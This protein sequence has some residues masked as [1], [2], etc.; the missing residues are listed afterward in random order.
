MT[1]MLISILHILA[2]VHPASASSSASI[3]ASQTQAFL[4]KT[5][6][7]QQQ[8]QQQQQRPI[9]YIHRDGITSPKDASSA[10][11]HES[12]TKIALV[13]LSEEGLMPSLNEYR[14]QALHQNENPVAPFILEKWIKPQIIDLDKHKA[15]HQGKKTSDEAASILIG[16]IIAIPANANI[17]NMDFLEGSFYSPLLTPSSVAS[18][19][20]SSSLSSSSTSSHNQQDALLGDM[21]ETIGCLVDCIILFYDTTCSHRQTAIVRLVKG[22]ER[23]KA[24]NESSARKDKDIHILILAKDDEAMEELY[25]IR[26][27]LTEGDEK[28]GEMIQIVPIKL[29]FSS[30][31]SNA[32]LGVLKIV[33][34]LLANVVD[35][36]VHHKEFVPMDEFPQFAK[37]VYSKLGGKVDEQSRDFVMQTRRVGTSAHVHASELLQAVVERK[38]EE[39]AIVIHDKVA[40]LEEKQDDVLMDDQKMPILE[41]GRDSTDILTLAS[42]VLNTNEVRSRIVGPFDGD[43]VGE[44]RGKFILKGNDHVRRLFENQLQSL[45]EYYG[46]RYESVIEKLQEDDDL[47][48]LDLDEDELQQRRIK[49]DTILA[50]EA[51]RS[52]ENF[53]IA[54]ENSIPSFVKQ[55]GMEE[56]AAGYRYESAL[57]GLIRDMLKATSDSQILDDEWDNVN[58]DI[59]DD[60]DVLPAKTRRG[61]VKWYEKLAARAL[62]FGVNYLQGWLAYQG[63]KKAAEERDRMM[64]KFPLF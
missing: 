58:G 17:D 3:S 11:T 21:A 30:K 38:L 39:F 40:E 35:Q 45:R 20:Q 59:D 12:Y 48:L 50:E 61:P 23:Q 33:R 55:E 28:L 44:Q 64:P 15:Q 60:E 5:K 54:A 62:V 16:S 13:H 6:E 18:S 34:D 24:S 14:I 37:R 8:Q 19:S 25:A 2:K 51:K 4:P 22:L 52:T 41:F 26:N 9:K 10:E 53:R 43:Y 63:I 27:V 49:H 32:E 1:I 47:D 57:D 36:S 42:N 31:D 46:R 29:H 7:L 56:L